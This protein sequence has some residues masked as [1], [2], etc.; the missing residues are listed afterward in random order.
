MNNRF[1]SLEES[2][3]KSEI[4]KE[5][6]VETA[7]EMVSTRKNKKHQ[8]WMTEGTLKLMDERQ[9]YKDIDT[10]KCNRLNAMIKRQCQEAKEAWLENL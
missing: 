9:L 3:E 6:I 7:K 5:A 8:K 2:N 1:E 10:K 4:F